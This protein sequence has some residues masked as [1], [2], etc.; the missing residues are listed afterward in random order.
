MMVDVLM[1][2]ELKNKLYQILSELPDE[3]SWLDYKAIPYQKN[4]RA[5]FIKDLCGFLNSIDSYGKDKFI[6]IGIRDKTKETF[7]IKEKP[8]QDDEYYQQLADIIEPRP[9]IETGTINFKIKN[10]EIPFGYI[11]ISKDNTNRVY[12]ISETYPE[13]KNGQKNLD[14]EEIKSVVYAST[15][16]I[17]K[18]SCNRILSEYD[19]REIYEIDRINQNV[20]LPIS[21]YYNINSSSENDKILKTVIIFG[22]WDENNKND[23]DVLSNFIGKSYEK[24]IL[25][26]RTLLK[27]K[28]CILKYKDNKWK[29][30]DKYNTIKKYAP[31]FFK[32]EIESF[33][34]AA[35]NILSE[36]N[37]KFDLDNDKRS[38]HNIYNKN[39]R[40]SNILRKS[41][42]ESLA[43]I[44]ANYKKFKNCKNDAGNL[45]LLVVR[46]VLKNNNWEIWASIGELLP[47]LAEAA[48]EEFLTQLDDKLKNNFE[49]IKKLFSEK[50]YYVTTYNYSTGL[51]W[52]LEL[53]AWESRNLIESCML[54]A[55]ISKID[56]EAINHIAN[57]ILPWYP[58]TKAPIENRIIVVK[59]ILKENP[60]EGWEL[61]K[62]LMPGEITVAS[63]SYKP[64]WINVID[65]N[66][67][68]ILQSDY[69]KQINAYIDL[70]ILN[71]KTNCKKIC[72]LIDIIDVVPTD[73][74]NKILV[75]LSSTNIISLNENRKFVIW[76]HLEDLIMWHKNISK[77]KHSLPNEAI[78]KLELLASNLKPNNILIFAK[79]YFRKDTWYLIDDRKNYTSSEKRLYR[80]QVELMQEILL[81]GY[82][83]MIDFV[84]TVEDSYIVGVCTV[85]AKPM[86]QL[87]SKIFDCLES[88]NINLIEFGKGYVYKNFT[89]K[90]YSWINSLDVTNWNNQRKINLLL[91]LPCNQ[92]TFNIVEKVMNKKGQLDY[93]KRVDIRSVTEINELN[94]AIKKLLLAKRP[95]RALWIISSKLHEDEHCIYDRETTIK[96]LKDLLHYQKKINH[97]DSYHITQIISNLQESDVSKTELFKIEWAYL[98][99]LDGKECRPKTL[100][101]MLSNDPNVYNDIL[102]LAYKPHSLEKNPDN[103]DEKIAI[104]AYRLLNQ[105]ELVPGLDNGTVNKKKINDWYNEML[106]VCRKSDRLEVALSNF[107]KVLFHSPEDKSGFWIDKNVAEI[108]N[109]EDADIIRNGFRIEAFNSMGIVNFDAEGSAFNNKAEEYYKKADLADKEGFYRL[110]SEARKLADTYKYESEN[111][112]DNY[113]DFE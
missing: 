97:M 47:F 16:Y 78:L 112:K 113:F 106:D 69:W 28:N 91:V 52:A 37:P 104:N 30:K 23:K 18:G 15:A 83:K 94:Y 67:S 55:K 93:W 107:G 10:V 79:R 96:C 42:A 44:T 89:F 2:E 6:I 64:K 105:W 87:E 54:L 20:S 101:C 11:F 63:P 7:G 31:E 72:D 102:C 74:F 35:I 111:T 49:M 51:Y 56:K 53:I 85:E 73:L 33:K 59:N 36:R 75:K 95:D 9:S 13:A 50:E 88:K 92:V 26:L 77:S 17:R 109:Q 48:P 41:I 58:Q 19:R 76:N 29:I 90:G 14:D 25:I 99:L 27:D 81:L 21:N 46:D 45:S 32:D 39:T 38:M 84:K 66:E 70:A 82:E 34:I 98:S 8:M 60:N 80:L 24:W 3:N 65:E 108:L 103:T 22:E 40:Y 4:K 71:S 110:A 1:N 5:D 12:S 43:I 100:E 68:D 62:K 61:L 86:K 57:I